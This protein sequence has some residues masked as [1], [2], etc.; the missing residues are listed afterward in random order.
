MNTKAK[1]VRRTSTPRAHRYHVCTHVYVFICIKWI[2]VYTAQLH[3]AYAC[4]CARTSTPR[5]HAYHMY[6]C[7]CAHMSHVY[8]CTYACTSTPRVHYRC[9]AYV[10]I[11]VMCIHLFKRV[12]VHVHVLVRLEHTEYVSSIFWSTHKSSVI[13]TLSA[14]YSESISVAINDLVILIFFLGRFFSALFF[15]ARF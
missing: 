12:H 13:C 9:H 14:L 1:A 11:Y 2:H 4:T 3:D 5:A 6:T 7:I 10:L 8:T 15:L